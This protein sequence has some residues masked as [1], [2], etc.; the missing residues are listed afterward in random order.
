MLRLKNLIKLLLKKNMSQMLL[1]EAFNE[2]A[3]LI[4][5]PDV[6]EKIQLEKYKDE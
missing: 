4:M 3:Y 6:T 5:N 1:P 2:S